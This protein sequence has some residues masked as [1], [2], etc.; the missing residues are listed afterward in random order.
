MSVTQENNPLIS[1]LAKAQAEMK[2]AVLN[3][4]NPHFKS[5]YAD[6]AAVREATLPALT[7]NGLAISQTTEFKDGQLVLKTRLWH[8]SG[9]SI[10]S[11]YPLPLN[12]DKPQAMG[13]AITYARRYCW[14][15]ICGVSSDEDDD[16]N[17]AEDEGKKK[18]GSVK[19]AAPKK[20]EK[21]ADMKAEAE[22]IKKDIDACVNIENLNAYIESQK[23]ALAKIKAASETAYDFLM[24]RANNRRGEFAQEAA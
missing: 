14:A 18:P 20:D 12:V 17:A 22:R 3:K 5:K 16:A 19:T 8:D 9:A 6:L 21:T 7:K 23:D 15:A 24:V 13:S 2:N 10:E 4:E 11:T 1:A